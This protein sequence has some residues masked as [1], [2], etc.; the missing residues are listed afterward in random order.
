[1]GGTS[2]L[3]NTEPIDRTTIPETLEEGLVFMLCIAQL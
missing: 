2:N 3:E 1:M